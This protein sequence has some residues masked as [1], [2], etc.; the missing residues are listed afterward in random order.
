MDTIVT[1]EQPFGADRHARIHRLAGGRRIGY[2][3]YGDPEGLPVFALHGTPGSRSMFALSDRLA[4]DKGIRL[5][6]PE[7]PGYGLSDYRRCGTLLEIA[8]DVAALANALGLDRFAIIGVSGGGP[9][10]VA[11][12]HAVP[13]RVVLLA[14]AGPIGPIADGGRQIR[15]SA[16]HRLVFARLA[17]SPVARRAFFW[18]LREM[19]MW[20]PGLAYR[21]LMARGTP[22]DRSVLAGQDVAANL[23]AAVAEGLRPG[24]KGAVQDLRLFCEPWRLAL[25]DIDVP[26][27]LW[28]GSDDTIVPPTGAYYLAQRLP[29]CRLDVIH[30]AGHYWVFGQFGLVLDAV[31]AA[32]HG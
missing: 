10:A 17:R 9:Y 5:I 20:T 13:E 30:G 24:I 3:E 25:G 19:L 1:T 27:A 4:R 29:N 7:R 32:L 2:A 8:G 16:F 26:A 31:A 11:V 6:A 15:L 22:S 18:S 28:Q 14:L 23:Q 21:G 12:A